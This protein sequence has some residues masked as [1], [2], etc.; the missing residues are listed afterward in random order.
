M[1]R[2]HFYFIAFLFLTSLCCNA[3]FSQTI[4]ASYNETPLAEV[5]EELEATYAIKFYFKNDWLTSKKVTAQLNQLSIEGALAAILQNHDLTYIL[6]EPNFVVLLPDDGDSSEPITISRSVEDRVSIGNINLAIDNATLSGYVLTGQDNLPLAGTV[7]TVNELAKRHVTLPNGFFEL[8]LPVGNYEIN[9]HHPTMVDYRI[10]IAL[11]SHGKINVLMF[12]DVTLLDE[13]VVSTEAVDQNVSKT[14]T[15]QEIIDIQTI[16]NIP[17][18]F[19]EADVFNS[20]L[21][22]PGVSKLG[23]GSSGINVRGGGVGQ[24]LIQID[25][26]TIYNPAHLFGFFSSFNADAVSKVN[27][28]RGSIPVEYGGRLSSVMDVQ[29]KSGNKKEISGVGG[30]GL[31][32]SRLLIEGPIRQDSTSFLA[33]V[34]LAY[35]DYM[36]S[37]ANDEDLDNSAA[38]FGDANLKIDHLFNSRNRMSINGYLSRD[39]FDFSQEAEYDYGNKALSVEWNSQLTNN[40]F[41]ESSANYTSYDYQFKEISEPQLSSSLAAGVNQFTFDNKFQTEIESHALSYGLSFT[42]LAID[43]GAYDKVSSESI[44]DPFTIDREKGVEGAVFVGDEFDLTNS[45]SFY[46]GLRYSFFTG[47]REGLEAT[48]HGAEPRLSVNFKTT[49]TSSIKLGYNKMRQYVHFISNTTSATPIDLWKLSN[50]TI[51]PEIADQVTLGYFRNFQANL[52]ETSAELF[53]KSTKDLIEYKNG[54]DLFL[55]QDIEGELIQGLGRAY[56]LELLVKKTRGNFNG[57]VSYT[58]S[59]S[60]IQVIGQQPINTINGGEFFSTNFDQP[61]N[62]SAFSKL[63]LSRRFSIN[64]NFTYNT[65]R[66]ISYPESVYVVRGVS[67]VDFAER[68]KYRIPD[69]HRLDISFVLET[70][71]KRVKKIEANWSFSIYNVYGRNNAYSV[72]FKNNTISGDPQAFQLSVIARPILAISYNFKF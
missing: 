64:T 17:A 39:R 32:N 49:S 3:Q 35:P 69:Y 7:V 21:S 54:A 28:Y 50:T 34:R 62:F 67:I 27:F 11:N 46:A 4:S 2:P 71:L 41:F 61:H 42:S 30:V 19:G 33:A 43:P 8:V 25:N 55:N 65:G 47:G 57:W 15:G 20:I 1:K 36:I 45:L 29:I 37:L 60:Q 59:R 22:L 9:F 13:V 70:S 18:F 10:S 38:F 52:Y 63:R 68:N 26:A 72:Y 12:E 5:I 53:Y 24:N 6:R 14:I 58:F 48:Y 23:E 44:I 51:K 56:G 40:T 31:I 16:K 66:P